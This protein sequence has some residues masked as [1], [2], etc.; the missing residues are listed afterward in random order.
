M[1]E[2]WRAVFGDVQLDSKAIPLWLKHLPWVPIFP[3]FKHQETGD[4]F[5]AS[6]TPKKGSNLVGLPGVAHTFRALLV[7]PQ[8]VKVVVVGQDPYPDITDATGQSF[9]QGSIEDWVDDAHRV[10]GSLK[11]ILQTAAAAVL[12]DERYRVQWKGWNELADNIAKKK[13]KLA[14]PRKLFPAYQKQGIRMR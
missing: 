2:P 10:A 13:V 4:I 9:E 8:S 1:P 7:P 5:Q 11:P 3:V 6:P 14:P 12:G